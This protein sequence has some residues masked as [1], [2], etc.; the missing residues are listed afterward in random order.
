MPH[1][2]FACVECPTNDA[3]NRRDADGTVVPT[4]GH[5]PAVAACPTGVRRARAR[6]SIDLTQCESSYV[7][8]VSLS[9]SAAGAGAES[10]GWA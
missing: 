8:R 10:W 6:S 4:V 9:A 7:P 3:M 5:R 2:I 1:C